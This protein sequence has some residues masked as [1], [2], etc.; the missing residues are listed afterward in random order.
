MKL[1]TVVLHYRH[2]PDVRATL[3]AL[4]CQVRVPEEIT[5][6]DNRSDDGS[7]EAIRDAFPHLHV[8]ESAANGGYAA[9]MNL[10]IRSL[11]QRG[12]DANLLLTHDC[13]LAPNA[14]AVLANRLESAPA[15]GAVGPLLGFRSDRER[16]YSAGGM[17]DRST[18]ETDQIVSPGAVVQWVG[19]SP[20]QVDWLDG[21]AIL[22]RSE[23]IR[24]AG[25]LSTAYFMYFE[26]SEYL[27]R[28]RRRGWVVE[29][30]P[31]AIAWQEPQMSTFPLDF[32]IRNRLRFLARNAPLRIFAREIGSMASW[33]ARRT[34]RRPRE[35]RTILEPRIRGVVAFALARTGPPHAA[36]VWAGR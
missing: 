11:L 25:P 30:V 18:W 12:V 15:V 21:A 17:I 13:V 16:V 31:Q 6:V 28:L 9:G 33:S 29:C 32:R 23:A 22:L 26:E 2:W 36:G 4:F 1:G 19:R 24:E 7:L 3:D 8:V 35:A 14:V 27:L 34:L 10:G 5:L 20:H